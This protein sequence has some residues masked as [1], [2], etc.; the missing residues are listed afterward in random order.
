MKTLPPQKIARK[1]LTNRPR[2]EPPASSC[3]NKMLTTPNIAT[4][5]IP[6]YAIHD[7]ALAVQ[8][9]PL[10]V[11]VLH[12]KTFEPC[13]PEWLPDVGLGLTLWQ[14]RFENWDTL[15]LCRCDRQ[16]RVIPTGFEGAEQ[17]QLCADRLAAQLRR[18]GVNPD[19]DPA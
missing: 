10:R 7:P 5:V 9:E 19:E 16:G 15:W 17:E 4:V 1:P 8:A 3:A 14:G 18:L 2:A 11:F 12:G 6:Y 13:S